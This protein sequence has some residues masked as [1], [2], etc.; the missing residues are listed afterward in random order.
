MLNPKSSSTVKFTE[1]TLKF[2]QH[3]FGINSVKEYFQSVY[4]T[5]ES[6]DSMLCLYSYCN[7]HCVYKLF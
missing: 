7:F 4:F 2:Y 3:I 1:A 5:F 6:V